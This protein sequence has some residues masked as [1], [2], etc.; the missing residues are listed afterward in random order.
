M[1]QV[2]YVF[3]GQPSTCLA[4][5]TFQNLGQDQIDHCEFQEFKTNP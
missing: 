3:G 5:S 2:G 1:L 4:H